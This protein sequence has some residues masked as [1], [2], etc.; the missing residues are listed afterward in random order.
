MNRKVYGES[1]QGASHVRSG[2]V[3]QDSYK[4]VEVSE[5]I[6]L[7]AVADG[8]GSTACPYSK[9]GSQIAVNVFCRVMQ[10]LIDNF[11]NSPEF[12]LTYLN[13]EGDTKIAQ[14][15]DVMWKERV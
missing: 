8:H 12:L 11:K 14:A 13:R 9:T 2:T 15:I 1:V 10:N 6:M 7:V 5:D 3:C 4:K